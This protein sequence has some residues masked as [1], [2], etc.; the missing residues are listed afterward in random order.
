M[1]RV[2]VCVCARVRALGC[3]LTSDLASPHF[4]SLM[5]CH[6]TLLA[7]PWSAASQPS[8][9][10]PHFVPNAKPLPSQTYLHLS[11]RIQ[12]GP[13]PGLPSGLEPIHSV[14]ELAVAGS[15]CVPLPLFPSA[16]E[17]L[18]YYPSMLQGAVSV[19]RVWF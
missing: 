6:T 1:A 17:C 8:P 9:S 2:G 11:L 16:R 19:S 10:H 4:F 3:F 15:A 14:W 5:R 18:G 7:G 12:H 13:T